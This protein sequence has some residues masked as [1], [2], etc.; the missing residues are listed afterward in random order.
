MKTRKTIKAEALVTRDERGR[1]Q[2]ITS[3]HVSGLVTAFKKSL[4]VRTQD[5]A[6][7]QLSDFAAEIARDGG[8]REPVYVTARGTAAEFTKSESPEK[9]LLEG[10]KG[11]RRVHALALAVQEPSI[12]HGPLV[13]TIDNTGKTAVVAEPV[14]PMVPVVVKFG[15]SVPEVIGFRLD[16]GA[17]LQLREVEL[18]L[19][20][21]AMM[22]GGE[23]YTEKR[24]VTTLRNHFLAAMSLG[25]REKLQAKIREIEEVAKNSKHTPEMVNAYREDAYFK[26]FRG[27]FQKLQRIIRSPFPEIRA[28]YEAE[29]SGKTGTFRVTSERIAAADKIANGKNPRAVFE[30]TVKIWKAEDKTEKKESK[31]WSTSTI[32][33][34]AAL[35]HDNIVVYTILMAV[36]GD[37]T[38]QANFIKACDA[39]KD[40]QLN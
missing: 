23:S 32:T 25:D 37:E 12:Y 29:K 15:L 21:E 40:T 38:A 9:L 5:E 14:N 36:A 13:E 22:R 30:E 16:H 28:N 33:E 11:F 19:C 39:V 26:A 27:R 8:V 10:L 3:L 1:E 31:A 24:M 34:K 17:Q 2:V 20:I 4:N 7:Y 18:L 6:G 35:Y